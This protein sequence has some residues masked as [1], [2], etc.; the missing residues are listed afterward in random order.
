MIKLKNLKKNDTNVLCDVIPEDSSN[1]GS[2]IVS[3]NGDVINYTLPSGYEWCINHIYHAA[4][5]IKELVN[6]G[7]LP[8]EITVMWN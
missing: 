4:R 3:V 7:T 6:K 5:K 1:S 2:L 8:S